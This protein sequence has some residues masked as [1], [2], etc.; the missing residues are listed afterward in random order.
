MNVDHD[1][2]FEFFNEINSKL[3][4]FFQRLKKKFQLDGFEKLLLMNFVLFF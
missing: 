2:I 4:F 3:G 1:L